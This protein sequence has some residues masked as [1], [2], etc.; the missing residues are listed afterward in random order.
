M[1]TFTFILGTFT[2]VAALPASV[3]QKPLT[4]LADIL[5][6]MLCLSFLGILTASIINFTKKHWF[7]GIV[8]FLMLPV[9]GIAAVFSSIFLMYA[10]SDDGFADDLAIPTDIVVAEPKK[11]PEPQAGSAE[12]TFQHALL[13]ALASEGTDDSSVTAEVTALQQLQ[14]NAPDVLRRYLAASPSWRV[15]TEHGD[16]FA[17]RRWLI[18]PVWQYSLHGYYTN[19]DI[20]TWQKAVVPEFQSRL[21]IGLSGNPWARNNRQQ[22]RIEAGDTAIAH[23]STGNE[24]QESYCVISAGDLVVE[25]FEQSSAKERRLTKTA[26]THLNGELQP[27]AQEPN[28]TTVQT[29]IP[30]AGIHHGEPSFDLW[31]DQ[32]GIYNSEIWINPGESGMLYLKAFEV[33]KGTALSADRLRESSNEWIGWSDNPKELFLSN[34]EFTIYEGDYGKPYA[35]RFEVWFAPDSG[36]PEWKLTERVFKI[37]GWQR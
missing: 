4:I 19:Y 8:N 5:F 29:A 13:S 21:T 2:F 33:T 37:E 30:A 26:L 1:L 10:I 7:K 15:F 28:W 32:P 27:I 11:M 17:T 31:E 36:A 35:A 9:C 22:T 12:D 14:Q 23:L 3:H 34:T 6:A 20:D 18:G 16:V 25:V 24:M